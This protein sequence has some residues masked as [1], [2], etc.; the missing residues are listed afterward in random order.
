MRETDVGTHRDKCIYRDHASS[1]L[2]QRL[3]LAM[4]FHRTAALPD[5]HD[6]AERRPSI[7][8]ALKLRTDDPGRRSPPPP[9]PPLA[10]APLKGTVPSAIIAHPS[11]ALEIIRRRLVTVGTGMSI[12]VATLTPLVSCHCRSR[13]SRQTYRWTGARSPPG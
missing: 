3:Y 2:Q 8:P 11:S 6:V 9:C 7:S 12:G 13:S 4:A 5:D 1:S 10:D